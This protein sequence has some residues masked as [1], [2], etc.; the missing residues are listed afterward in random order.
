MPQ[1]TTVP[2]SGSSSLASAMPPS[3]TA[4]FGR[5]RRTAFASSAKAATIVIDSDAPVGFL[6]LT[7]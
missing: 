5:S 2:C 3:T 7:V 6:S 4:A 1:T